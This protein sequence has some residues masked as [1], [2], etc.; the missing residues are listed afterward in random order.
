MSE[1]AMDRME[2][3]DQPELK[4]GLNEPSP[5]PWR[6]LVQIATPVVWTL[7]AVDSTRRALHPHHSYD[8][9]SMAV[10]QWLN[11]VGWTWL[12][13]R[14]PPDSNASAL[15]SLNLNGD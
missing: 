8:H 14:K 7:M 4:K 11:A 13:F 6:R 3:M 5:E 1:T 15:T 12:A 10:L 9:W 2:R